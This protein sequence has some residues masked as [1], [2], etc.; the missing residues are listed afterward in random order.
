MFKP[1]CSYKHAL[2]VYW[3]SKQWQMGPKEQALYLKEIAYTI[4]NKKRR[5]VF[6][7]NKA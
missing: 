3:A 7:K 6:F 4:G 1:S 2:L 5:Y